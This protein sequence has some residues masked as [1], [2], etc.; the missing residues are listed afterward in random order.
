MPAPFPVPPMLVR[1]GG[2]IAAVVEMIRQVQARAGEASLIVL[3]A[4]DQRAAELRAT[5]RAPRAAGRTLTIET[6]RDHAKRLLRELDPRYRRGVRV[7]DARQRRAVMRNLLRR[8]GFPATPA[9]VEHSLLAL[10]RIKTQLAGDAVVSAWSASQ[11]LEL[12]S[13][14][15]RALHARRAVDPD[16]LLARPVRLLRHD[17]AQLAHRQ[18]ARILVIDEYN[19]LSP[20]ELELVTTLAR[21]AGGPVAVFSAPDKARLDRFRLEF[22]DAVESELPL[23]PALSGTTP[24]LAAAT[25]RRRVLAAWPSGEERL[26]CYQAT[27]EVDEAG[28]IAAEIAHLRR[29]GLAPT[30]I[31]VAYRLGAAADTLQEAF[32]RASIPVS[33]VGWCADDQDT[34]LDV[35][36]YLRLVADSEDDPAF[37]RALGRPSRVPA[38]AVASLSQL[39]GSLKLSLS[40]TIPHAAMLSSLSARTRLALRQFRAQLTGWHA[41]KDTLPLADLVDR[42]LEESGYLAWAQH[43]HAGHFPLGQVDRL[44][45]A[46]A[47]FERMEGRNWTGFVAAMTPA[48]SDDTVRLVSWSQL[49]SR[50]SAVVF[51][52]GLEDQAVPLDWALADGTALEAERSH[53]EALKGQAR[54]CTFLTYALVRMV[55][56]TPVIR[57]PSRFL[58]EAPAPQPVAG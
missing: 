37:A 57:D 34:R 38:A 6:C 15:D 32:Q 29:G 20:L 54:V 4:T 30:E 35:L 12:L 2:G 28:F 44:R 10:S 39:A 22:P 3:T 43:R 17:P 56:G 52:T 14:Y 8:L 9:A 19:R 11:Q 50:D 46:A 16:D 40:A 47:E 24:A 58:V 18:G 5:L 13:R 42:L 48:G 36:A 55:E 31:A 53:F 1:V 7:I 21:Q 41:L 23:V 25:A 27:D 49:A 26:V 51:L 45:L 33:R